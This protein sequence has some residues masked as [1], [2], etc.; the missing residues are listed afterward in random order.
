[1]AKSSSSNRTGQSPDPYLRTFLRQAVAIIA[2]ER[3][4]NEASQSKLQ[5]L[6]KQLGLSNSAYSAALEKLKRPTPATGLNS[7]EKKFVELI[8]S[9]MSKISGD[10]LTIK[11]ENKVIDLAERK[12]QISA[13]RA[14][15]LI[16]E[17]AQRYD[18]GTISHHDAEVFATSLLDDAVGAR[19]WLRKEDQQRLLHACQKWGM[20]KYEIETAINARCTRNR[21]R[22]AKSSL[23]MLAAVSGVAFMLAALAYAV[24]QIDWPSLF[25]DPSKS[26]VEDVAL[27]A[28]A[29][30]TNLP[31]WMPQA[32]RKKAE[33]ACFTDKRLQDLLELEPWTTANRQNTYLKL[34]Q[35]AM[36][37]SKPNL[38]LNELISE[39]YF[40]EPDQKLATLVLNTV[41]NSITALDQDQTVSPSILRQVFAANQLLANFA[42]VGD[43]KDQESSL[44]QAQVH[45]L[46][47]H[48]GQN[49]DSMVSRDQLSMQSE[50][51]LTEESWRYLLSIQND[52]SR[53]AIRLLPELEQRSSNQQNA[54]INT[55]RSSLVFA[56][57]NNAGTDW[58]QIRQS[59]KNSIN[60]GDSATTTQ[61]IEKLDQLSSESLSEFVAAEL[62]SRLKLDRKLPR[63]SLVGELRKLNTV[64]RFRGYS[65][66]LEAVERVDSSVRLIQDELVQAGFDADAGTSEIS[67]AAVPEL[68]LKLVA[69]NN[70]ALDWIRS[71]EQHDF[72][73]FDGRVARAQQWSASAVRPLAAIRS[74]PTPFERRQLKESIEKLENSD[75]DQSFAR[76][77]AIESLV[78][79]AAKFD[80]IR[81]Q[82]SAVLT[83]L[84]LDDTLDQRVALAVER[85]LPHFSKWSNLKLAISDQFFDSTST[86]F[87]SFFG[88]MQR[89][90]L[91]LDQSQEDRRQLFSQ[92]LQEVASD[93]NQKYR[94]SI[95]R[96]HWSDIGQ[97]L[98]KLQ[99]QR[100]RIFASDFTV[101][102]NSVATNIL[103]GIEHTVGRNQNNRY[104]L[105]RSIELVKAIA[106][107]ELERLVLGNQILSLLHADSNTTAADRQEQ[108]LRN[109]LDRNEDLN[110]GQRLMISEILLMNHLKMLRQQWRERIVE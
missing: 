47:S 28:K 22:R 94:D 92:I 24:F 65:T 91:Q 71:A 107:S 102:N 43:Q 53:A 7:Y 11:A 79:I 9:E 33:L 106:N 31:E 97:R 73:A 75:S 14:H 99:K 51:R 39:L 4:L 26:K 72:S 63:D 49:L 5:A 25:P 20:E 17:T 32:L 81:Y 44:R 34:T 109:L 69:S 98:T 13:I 1:M 101:E 55:M 74:Q 52:E 66:E 12:Y 27:A 67:A 60:F 62:A 87:E 21:K 100:V 41:K 84:I 56:L 86:N 64:T 110:Q 29:K 61:W 104:W 2:A 6:A 88:H 70:I 37:Y 35:L 93:I 95:S 36:S 68:L 105:S 77:S 80:D 38:A 50:R 10:V 19:T 40:L 85:A 45:R 48:T 46:L 57:L 83:R 89:L 58:R 59:I 78:K 23:S 108:Q 8:S 16:E 96:N 82:E 90:G 42:T 76:I 30:S 15:Q 54:A 3:G 103:N 18:V